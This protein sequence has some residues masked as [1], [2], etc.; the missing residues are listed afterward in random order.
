MNRILH[1]IHTLLERASQRWASLTER[2][3]RLVS[4]LS[5]ALLL[6]VVALGITSFR[7]GLENGQAV[8]AHKQIAVEKVAALSAGFREAEAARN[9]IESR[10]RGSPVRLFG[11]LEEIAKRQELIIGDM[12]DRGTDSK[13][14]LV[15]STVEMSFTRIA[16]RPLVEFLNE[17]E[18]NPRLVK[19]EK[20]R[21]RH[22]NDDPELLDVTLTVSTYHLT[23]S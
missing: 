6:T 9:R 13:D 22:R 3:R 18:R 19:V 14:G 16:L 23:E 4:L 17:I 5:A 2:E 10:L 7:K 8:V 21:V 12:Q 1:P 11:Y 20:L 15:R